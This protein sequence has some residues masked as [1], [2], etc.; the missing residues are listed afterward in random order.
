MKTLCSFL[1]LVFILAVGTLSGCG[2]NNRQ[3]QSLTV[4][5]ASTAAQGGQAQFTATG[6]FSSMPMS[7]SPASVSWWQSPPIIDPPQRHVWSWNHQPAICGA[8]FR[9]YRSH[10]HHR[11]CAYGSRRYK[12]FHLIY[13][14][15]TSRASTYGHAG[16]WIR[17]SNSDNELPLAARPT[18]QLRGAWSPL[19]L[20]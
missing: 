10:Y 18:I 6:Q 14:I 1:F 17:G 9:L 15:C 8:M 13:D 12:P 7:V 19:W 16:K 3:L 11:D 5:P 20:K 2:G 4:S